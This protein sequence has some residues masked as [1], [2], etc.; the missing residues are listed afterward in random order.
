MKQHFL[1]T[2]H[3]PSSYDSTIRSLETRLLTTLTGKTGKDLGNQAECLL[4][5]AGAMV[6]HP[7]HRAQTDQRH[8]DVIILRNRLAMGSSVLEPTSDLEIQN[9]N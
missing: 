4:L 1:R 3:N 9:T 7:Y 2:K 5:W 8:A 6:E